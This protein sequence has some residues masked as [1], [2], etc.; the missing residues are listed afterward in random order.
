MTL[1]KSLDFP[2]SH[3][4]LPSTLIQAPTELALGQ[5]PSGS[6]FVLFSTQKQPA[7]SI[8]SQLGSHQPLLKPFNS[9]PTFV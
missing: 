8:K 3:L 7:I 5:D 9:S 4:S 6:L 2:E 1:S